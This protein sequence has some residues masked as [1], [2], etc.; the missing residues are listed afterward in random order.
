METR[1][2]IIVKKTSKLADVY[3]YGQ[4]KIDIKLAQTNIFEITEDVC[5]ESVQGMVDFLYIGEFPQD[6]AKGL[7]LLNLHKMAHQ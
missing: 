7:T 3:S 4:L 5:N 6:C 2:I 1:Y